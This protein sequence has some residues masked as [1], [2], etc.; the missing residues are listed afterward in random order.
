MVER[1]RV[2]VSVTNLWCFKSPIL[3]QNIITAGGNQYPAHWL[4]CCDGLN[5][6]VPHNSPLKPN[7]NV[8]IFG[9]GSFRRYLGH[10]G[11]A[12]ISGIRALIRRDMRDLVLPAT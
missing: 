2:R 6:Y 11:G 8:M 10:E 1:E 7:P 12:L 5:V 3:F 9:E 4:T